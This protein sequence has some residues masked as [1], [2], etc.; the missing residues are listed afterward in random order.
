[1]SLKNLACLPMK[2]PAGQQLA[3][4]V[5]EYVELNKFTKEILTKI[6]NNATLLVNSF[7]L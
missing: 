4:M 7:F 6:T 1:M 2:L 3:A 5:M